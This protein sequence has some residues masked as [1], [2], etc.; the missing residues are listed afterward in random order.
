MTTRKRPSAVGV[1]P[2]TRDVNAAQ[3]A[4]TAL[5]LRLAGHTYA[6]IAQH[7]GYSHKGA[8]HH[9]IM[10]E[11]QRALREPAEEALQLEVMRLDRL[12]V[13]WWPDALKKDPVALSAVMKI[14]ER[15]GR[16]TGMDVAPRVIPNGQAAGGFFIVGSVAE[17]PADAQSVIEIPQDVIEAI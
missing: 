13:A 12:L 8:A 7:C 10:R 11:M 1:E 15:R 14:S 3:R 6:D 16:L 2:V 5:Q 17:V 4:K 9:A